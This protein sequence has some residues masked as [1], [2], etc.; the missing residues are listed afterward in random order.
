V[1]LPAH[2]LAL[3]AALPDVPR[4]IQTRSLLRSAQG[5]LRMSA[6]GEGAVVIQRD[7]PLATLVG[8]ADAA[9]LRDTVAGVS[10]DFE[11]L[12]QLT[13]LDGVRSALRDWE[14]ALAVLHVPGRPFP[15]TWQADSGVETS[16]PPD[17][18]RLA[19]LPRDI[20]RFV[21]VA[22]AM[23]VR[24]VDGRV[25]A[26]CAAESVTE[27]LWDVSV[28][29]LEGHRRRG[30][31]TACFQA[32]AAHMAAQGRQPVWGAEEANVASKRL[33]AKLGFRAVDRL[34]VVSPP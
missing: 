13:E 27:S 14:V 12:V 20:R 15:A 28:D 24:L 22:S 21:G 25:A 34:A 8:S 7:P 32:L 26:V 3:A 10:D 11:L 19:E 4:W 18:R 9:L 33:A 23:A 5:E 16:A 31:A 6:G 30:H 2:P 17:P 1:P 29:T